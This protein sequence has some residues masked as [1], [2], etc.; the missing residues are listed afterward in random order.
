MVAHTF[1]LSTSQAKADRPIPVSS[2]PARLYNKTMSQK[3][4]GGAVAQW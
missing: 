3:K 4:G 1:N 2:R